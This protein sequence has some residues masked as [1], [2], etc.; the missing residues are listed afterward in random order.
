MDDIRLEK[1][2]EVVYDQVFAALPAE[3][4]RTCPAL[5]VLAEV[6]LDLKEANNSEI[7]LELGILSGGDHACPCKGPRRRGDRGL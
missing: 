2:L 3:A 5:K 4:R 1:L 7:A 6:L